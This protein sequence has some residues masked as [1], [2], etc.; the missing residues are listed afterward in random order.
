MARPGRAPAGLA[1]SARSANRRV[2]RAWRGAGADQRLGA[3]AALGLFAS[4]FLP[5]YTKTVYFVSVGNRPELRS[6][7]LSAFGAFSFVEAAV[8]LVASAVLALLFARAERRAFHLPGGD[9]AVIAAAGLWAAAL[10][11]YRLLDKPTLKGNDTVAASEGV[12]WG[13]FVALLLALTLAWA[14]GRVRAAGR[15]EPPLSGRRPRGRA[16]AAPRSPQPDRS[17]RSG[18]GGDEYSSSVG[19]DTQLRTATTREDR[20]DGGVGSRSSRRPGRRP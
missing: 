2:V 17:D 4:M 20:P 19:G 14:G 10:I 8:L 1:G 6:I 16:E 5:W 9:G 18:P 12:Q 7:S 13:V 15:S 3:A 11:F